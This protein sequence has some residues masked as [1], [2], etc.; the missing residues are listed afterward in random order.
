MIRLRR[1]LMTTVSPPVSTVWAE[2]AP[3][4]P[5]E[6]TRQS[7]SSAVILLTLVVAMTTLWGTPSLGQNERDGSSRLVSSLSTEELAKVDPHLTFAL[8]VPRTEASLRSASRVLPIY[9]ESPEGLSFSV[10]IRSNLTDVELAGLGVRRNSR[11]GDVVTARISEAVLIQAAA[12]P[13][14]QVIESE[15]WM[16]ADL[17]RSTVDA[18]AYTQA[19][20][21]TTGLTGSGV[22]YGLIDDGIDVT[23][24]DFLDSSGR[25]RI[26]FVWDQAN[27]SRAPSGFNYGTEFTAAQIDG[28]P[29]SVFVNEGGD[30]S[31]VAGISV[32]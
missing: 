18:R 31:D 16:Y 7:P 20:G 2:A 19:G 6:R 10:L 22:L 24:D 3:A 28:G 8:S 30:G 5:L 27:D 25:S 9:G 26:L 32:G 1:F 29:A 14:V 15:P 4:D 13:G 21:S 11:I 12:H 17:D 23:H